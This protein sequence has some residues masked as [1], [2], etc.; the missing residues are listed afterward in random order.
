M[1]LN[2]DALALFKLAGDT[3][4]LMVAQ[5]SHTGNFPQNLHNQLDIPERDIAR[6]SESEP[7]L[8]RYE[9]N[10]VRLLSSA[11]QRFDRHGGQGSTDSVEIHKAS[12]K[13]SAAAVAVPTSHPPEAP[14]KKKR[15][16]PP[17]IRPQE[18]IPPAGASQAAAP[19]PSALEVAFAHRSQLPQKRINFI[20][21]SAH[22]GSAENKLSC[23]RR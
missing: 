13:A 1:N 21:N 5:S 4:D 12:T 7:N 2:S 18:G 20:P 10:G 6:M 8:R 3:A 14:V 16:R 19:A 9:K 11:D 15:G 23:T 22:E 17:K